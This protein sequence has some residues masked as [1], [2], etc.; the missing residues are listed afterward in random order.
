MR[1]VLGDLVTLTLFG[2]SHGEYIGATLDGLSAGVKIDEDFLKSQLSKRRP[3]LT[4]D[5]ARIE[6]DDY[7]II[8]GVFNGYST[9]SPIT[10]IIRNNNINSKSYDGDLA[11][12]NHADYVA[13]KKYNGYND[14]R[15][16]GHFSGR[17]TAPIVALGSIAIKALENKGIKIG[18]HILRCGGVSDVNFNGD[19]NQLNVLEDKKI[20][21]IDDIEDKLEK[22][23]LIAKNEGDSIGGVIQSEILGL[24]VGVGEP[25]FSSL[26]GVIANAVFSIGGIKGIEFGDGF[27]FAEGYGSNHNDE[28]YMENCDIKMHANHNGGIN[29]GISNGNP[30]IFNMAVKPTPSIAK[31]QRTINLKTNENVELEIKGRHDPAIIRR[32]CI[33]ISSIVA[34]TL[35]DELAKKYGVDYFTK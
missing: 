9:G 21:V 29:G 18:T 1:N 26:E 16:G 11:R 22:E 25:W 23:I 30:I 19:I 28:Y 5:T 3:S 35:L 17:L 8:S 33:V 4:I 10:I 12:P 20:P 14:Y 24:P 13:Y 7:Q 6:E 2:E 27:N 31:K 32:I 34:I 15:G